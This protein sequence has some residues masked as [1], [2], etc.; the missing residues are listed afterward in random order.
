M[1]HNNKHSIRCYS[2]P[3]CECSYLPKQNAT[4]LVVD[5]SLVLNDA[6]L[7]ELL[8]QGFRRSGGLTYR[9][10]C[11][12]CQACIATRVST[13]SFTPNRSQRRCWRQN[14]ELS[15]S[16]STT[17]FTEAQFELYC[18]YLAARHTDSEM[19]NPTPEEYINFLTSPGVTTQFHEFRHQDKLLA[20]A[21]VD[22]TANGLSAV[23]T[24]FDPNQAQRGLGTF[25]IL[26]MIEHARRLH[27]PWVY[28]GYWI[29]ACKKMRYKARFT[30]CQGYINE[31]WQLI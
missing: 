18:R 30:P 3:P 20:V 1:K 26:W 15:H 19:N 25:T 28:L 31:H 9:P 4:N 7:G 27:L 24:F 14:Q 16:S 21:V 23:Y 12:N 29:E 10:N 2:T 13:E 22:H 8:E 11:I 17:T 6:L 5:P